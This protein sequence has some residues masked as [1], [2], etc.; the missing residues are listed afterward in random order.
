ML[1][2]PSPR[3][4]R[5]PA[6][7]AEVP[8]T[9]SPTPTA[10]LAPLPPQTP[11]LPFIGAALTIGRQGLLDYLTAA[12]RTHG[13]VFRVKAGPKYLQII[14]HPDAV[15]R[16]LVSNG[17]NYVKGN[18]YDD[19]RQLIGDGLLTLEG[20]AWKKRRRLAQPSFHRDNI[21]RFA[22]QMAGATADLLADWRQRIPQ[23]GVLDMHVE[24]THLTM[25]IVTETL[26]GW[27]VGEGTAQS[28]TAAFEAAVGA[29]NDRMNSPVQLPMAVPTPANLRLRKSLSMLHASVDDTIARA[30][31]EKPGEGKPHMIRMLIDARD[32]DTGDALSDADLR[33]EAM[34]FFF[35]GHETTA[36]TL[37]WG[38]TLWTQHPEVVARL[39]A[40][41]DSVLGGRV[42]TFE[43]VARLTY[44]RQVVDEILR[45][46]P[47]AW[48]VARNIVAED[49]VGGFRMT[50]GDIALPV[51]YFVHRHPDFWPDPERFDPER[52]TPDQVKARPNSAYIPFILGGRMCI[53]NVFSLVESVLVL[54]MLVQAAEFTLQ[55]EPPKAEVVLTLRPRGPVPVAVNWR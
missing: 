26:F 37:T 52:F 42:P 50:P 35:A 13:D 20:D 14:A 53:G 11:G 1:A 40:E 12:W 55:V 27:R 29:V 34:T 51:L 54:A 9:L 16:V 38:F 10:R 45:L 31:A 41:V 43:D 30:R 47:P 24:M 44:T 3:R 18:A 23:G 33:D 28:A 7:D 17:R 32:A 36:L 25:A 48:G 2:P 39:K 6:I 4:E 15:E 8:M 5:L 22:E 46:R 49:T 21:R 19:V